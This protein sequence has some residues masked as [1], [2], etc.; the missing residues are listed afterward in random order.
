MLKLVVELAN[1]LEVI[2]HN[3][4]LLR[5]ISGVTDAYLYEQSTVKRDW[6]MAEIEHETVENTSNEIIRQCE[7]LIGI[8]NKK[9]SEELNYIAKSTEKQ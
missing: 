7:E 4:E 3:A 9:L 8:V 2:R 5:T 1:K 6:G